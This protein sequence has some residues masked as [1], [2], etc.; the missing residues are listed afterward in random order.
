MPRSLPKVS[1]NYH[2]T[3]GVAIRK[4]GGESDLSELRA[5]EQ[6]LVD[7]ERGLRTWDSGRGGQG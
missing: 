7:G 4:F 5:K 1:Q 2:G 6:D 3:S